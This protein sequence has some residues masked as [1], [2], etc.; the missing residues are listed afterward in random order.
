MSVLVAC[1]MLCYIFA[2]YQCMLNT[3]MFLCIITG[4]QE[5]RRVYRPNSLKLR[6][7][8]YKHSM[9]YS[10]DDPVDYFCKDWNTTSQCNDAGTSPKR[11]LQPF[12]VPLADLIAQPTASR[13]PKW[14]FLFNFKVKLI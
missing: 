6:K 1:D 7:F 10:D 8:S 3:V 13:A 12:T 5:L 11:F 14:Y 9:P 2:L 4:S